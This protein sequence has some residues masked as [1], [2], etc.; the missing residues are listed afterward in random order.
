M[1]PVSCELLIAEIK[2]AAGRLVVHVSG[3][4]DMATV[5]L[6]KDTV[7]TASDAAARKKTSMALDLTKVT[8][9]GVTG[10]GVLVATL[11]HCNALGVPLQLASG[12]VVWKAL[13]SA[14][15]DR[16]FN[17]IAAQPVSSSAA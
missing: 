11:G 15:L 10:L 8:F 5:S 7:D 9:F 1:N 17:F 4:V 2:P 6:L 13:R 3:E 14:G 12:P 16:A